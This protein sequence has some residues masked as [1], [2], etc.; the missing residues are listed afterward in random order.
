MVTTMPSTWGHRPSS[1]HTAML[2]LTPAGTRAFE[3]AG[4]RFLT[5]LASVEQA[6]GMPAVAVQDA[7]RAL[8]VAI[9]NAS[10]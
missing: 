6:L 3:V 8:R 1:V 7:L 5:A 2:Q 4:R 9:A 10:R